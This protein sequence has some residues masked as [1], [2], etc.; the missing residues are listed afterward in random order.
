MPKL[1]RSKRKALKHVFTLAR[2]CYFENYS[3]AEKLLQEVEED[4]KGKNLWG[5]GCYLAV[6]GM[7]TAGREGN[8][9]TFFWKCKDSSSKELAFIRKY[10]IEDLSRDNVDEF[11]EGFLYGWLTI[12]DSFIDIHKSLSRR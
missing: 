3:A 1:S 4:I 6:K 5:S 10:I 11:E 2:Y 8:P 9:V 12:I 7:I